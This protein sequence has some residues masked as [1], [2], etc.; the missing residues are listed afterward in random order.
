MPDCN[1][2]CVWER[3]GFCGDVEFISRMLV[4]TY[5]VQFNA[6]TMVSLLSACST[7]YNYG[8]GRFLLASIDVN[9][10]PLN[11]ILVTT[12]IDMY[13]KCGNVEKAWRIFD[14][15]SCKKLP[16]WNAIITGYVQHGL[17]EEAID[18][19]CLRKVVCEM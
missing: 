12:L 9:K 15:V 14:G 11:A 8:V 4:S 17:F 1:D 5:E 2:R 6:A 18:L 7:L 10:I 13:S 3:K 19:Y 16:P